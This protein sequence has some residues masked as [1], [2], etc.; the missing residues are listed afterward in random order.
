V[1]QV[2]QVLAS[3]L[4]L[5]LPG[6]ATAQ[7][8]PARLLVTVVDPSGGVLPGADVTVTGNEDATRKT[9]IAPTKTTDRGLA[10]L[11]GVTP[12]HYTVAAEYDGFERAV[13]KDVRLRSGD[14][15]HIIVLPLRGLTDT[16]TVGRDAQEA[17]ADRV[18][19][20]GSAL[21]REQIDALSDDPAE[22]QRQLQEM[23]GTGA[24]L[25]ID[26]FEGGS[27]PP[28]AQIKAIHITRDAF[29]AENH[30]A[31]GFFIDIITQPGIGA[32]R[33]NVN[34]RYR[35]GALSG[36]SP[37]TPTKGPEQIRNYGGNVGGSVI[38]G[39]SSF[40]LSING[41][42]Q[43]ETPNIN[44][45]LPDGTRRSEAMAVRQPNNRFGA[46]S[47]F[48][49][50]LTTDQTLRVQY[51]YNENDQKNLG[52]GGYDQ[53][54][55]SYSN[56]DRSHF[57]RIQEA[58]PLG[59]RFFTNTRVQMAWS[60]T[61]S[62]SVMQAPTIRVNDAFTSGG[63]QVGG[64]RHT[65]GVNVA[66]DLDYVRGIH[67]VRAG[68]VLDSGWKRSD[69]TS[70]YL[71]TYVFE[72]LDA[73]NAGIPRTYTRR[74]GDPN[75]R[76]LN[77]QTGWYLQDDIRV[78]R[79]LTVTPG[80]R[81]ETQ[82][83]L[84]G[85][86]EIMPRFGITWSPMKSG[87]TTL[88]TSWGVFYDWLAETT[89]EQTLRVDGFR[90]Q[91]LNIVN[92]SYPQTGNLGVIPPTNRYLLGD[93]IAMART[94]RLSAGIEQAFTPRMRGSAI[95]TNTRG[96]G[97]LRGQNLNLP[98][99]GVRPNA[100][101][102]NIVEVLTDAESRA[103]ALSLNGNLSLSPP[104]PPGA[105]TGPRFDWK[106]LSFNGNFSIAKATNNSDGAFRFPVSG[107]LDDD[108]GPSGNDVRYRSSFG[109]NTGMLRN[110]NVNI[111]ASWS[112]GNPYTIRT[113]RD[114]NGD[115][116]FNDRPVGEGRNR[117][118]T[119]GQFNV[120][121]FFNYTIAFGGRTIAL[122]PG[123]RV[124]VGGV[125]GATVETVAQAPAKRYR[126][127]FNAQIQNLTNHKNYTGYSGLMTSPFF[128]TPTS[129][130]GTRK[131][132]LGMTLSF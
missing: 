69:D 58:G 8:R 108:W 23:A 21:T 45:A 126:V 93:D 92:P 116:E 120:S 94:V 2:R 110:L 39:R 17:A 40:S 65:R 79:G 125:G 112:T 30:G 46:F 129:V 86:G 104:A 117:A 29:A 123:I 64:G 14:N 16:V 54:E 57:L 42:N 28:K 80:V 84:P 32:W 107:N 96:T 72:N 38:K 26:S 71:G 78:R 100:T 67:S 11:E 44:V 127:S 85:L 91:E 10:T 18:G 35:G 62:Q 61:E 6:I 1:S 27:L 55:R 87:K 70:N 95:Y 59:R 52:I 121:G 83:L 124:M 4:I 34:L 41:N 56:R 132:D 63:A 128:L 43:Y 51:S 119:D 3:V 48:D 68:V 15:K 12:G 115:L 130:T 36:R 66:S 7:T 25:R 13:L 53:V 89:Y 101:F 97:L 102:A 122:P 33:G 118:R 60:D 74:I 47:F 131:I 109:F 98:I 24:V 82:S 90:Q 31:G 88:R 106:R 73:F 50:A 75:I 81:Y 99:A 5:A 76:F 114:D 19:R 105:T 113:G 9:P 103:Q 111:F 22:M 20:F 49:Y 37:F 77:F